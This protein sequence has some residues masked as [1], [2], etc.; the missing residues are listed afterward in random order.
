[1]SSPSSP[2]T[3]LNIND[4]SEIL[5]QDTKP[6]QEYVLYKYRFVVMFIFIIAANLNGLAFTIFLP[7]QTT[8]RDA[9]DVSLTWVNF[10]TLLNS[11]LTYVPAN[12]IANYII[13]TYG[14]RAGTITGTIL[15]V[16]GFWARIFAEND[17]N[18]ILVG[19]IFAGFGT[20]YFYSTPQKI[21]NVWFGA[22]ERTISTPTIVT[23]FYI[24]AS[25][26]TII[27]QHFIDIHADPKTVRHQLHEL[28]YLSAIVGIVS[29]VFVIIFMKSKPK[30]PP[31]PA[32]AAPKYNYKK[33]LK[34]LLKDKNTL[35]LLASTS[36]IYA[37]SSTYIGT[38][39]Q[40]VDP[41]DIDGNQV[42]YILSVA[43]L[44]GMLGSGIGAT[45][46]HKTRRFN[47]IIR[48][49]GVL[50]LAMLIVNLFAAETGSAVVLGVAVLVFKAIICPIVSI[51]LE[52]AVELSFPIAESTVGGFWYVFNQLFA[53]FESIGVDEI[54][55]WE[56]TR[57]GAR[58]TFFLIIGV[59]IL[60]MVP[61]LFIKEDLKR[62]R[63]E[64]EGG[65]GLLAEGN[66]ESL[67]LHQN[68]SAETD[69]K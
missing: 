61:L 32:A 56:N 30:T 20:P 1:M 28:L 55:E 16:I 3:K 68:V 67:K 11:N 34:T 19:Q 26:G 6:S 4:S 66:D 44:F 54:L 22:K 37:S 25:L 41:L 27:P 63:Y 50:T 48:T 33:S 62:E 65:K 24:A 69:V 64:K 42:G 51:S 35:L 31:S 46:L 12:F 36:I 38:I 60:A 39:Q 10:C 43:L 57:A 40:I 52:Y 23:S 14:L 15:T 45:I 7:L 9:Y 53:T 18:W 13:D 2:T 21:S 58:I 17:F 29:C 49:I 5:N 8:L 47:A 59:Q